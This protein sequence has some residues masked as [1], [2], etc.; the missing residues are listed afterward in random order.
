MAIYHLNTHT[1]GRAAGHSAVAAAAYRSASKLVDER[2]GEVFDFTRKGGVLSAEIVTPAGVP[3]PERAALWNAAEAAEKR[4]DARVARE[5]RAALPHELNEADRRELATRMGQAIA[6]RYGVA[7]DVCIHA[8]D[9]E[10][11]DRNFHVHM[12]ATTR[13][14]GADGALGAKAV[15]E[16]ANK[17]RQKAGIPGTSQGDIT[18]IRREWAELTNEALERAGISARIDHRSYADQGVEL[19]PTR[20]I[21]SDAVAMER[22]GLDADRIDIHKADRQEQARQIAERPEIILDKITATQAV[23][24]RRDIAAELNR[25]IDDAGQF[26]GLLTKLENSPLL[27]E[28]EPANGRDPAKFSTREMIDT[29]RGMVECAER[30]ARAGRHGVS[31]PITNAAI[32]GAGTLSAEQQNA[33]RHVLKPGSLAVVIGDAGTGKSFSM[34]VAREAWQAQ[35]FNVRG[36]ALAGKAADELQAGSGIE[37]RTLASLEFAWK[38]GKDKLTSRDVLVIDEAGMIGSRQLGRVLKAAEQAGAKVVLLGDD[39]QLAAIEAGAA[40]RAV[41]QHVGAAE[42]TEVRRQKHAWMREAGQQL[43]RGSVADGLAAYA[44]RGHVQIHGSREAARDALAASYVADQGK[45]SQII[46]AHSNAD[47]Q[48]L[49]QAVRDARKER[50]ELA[51]SARFVTE[52]G[53]REFAAGDRI[54]FLK[55]DRDLGVKNGTLGTVERAEDGR[56]AVRLDSG[57]AR[58]VQASQYAA[59]DHGYAVTIHKAQGVT[60][61]RAYLLATPGMDRSLAYVGMTR[62]R[63]AATLFAGADDFTDRR[64]GRLVDHG[65]APYEHDPKNGLSYFA[66]LENDKGERHTI[67]GVDLERAIADSGAQIGDRIGLAHGGAQ[68]VRLP[69]GRMVERNTWHVQTAEELA[70]GKLAQVMGRQRV[71]EST[72]DYLPDFAEQRGF[73]GESVLRRWVERGRAKVA[74]LAGRMRDAL[75]RGLE[76]HGRPDLMPATDIAGTPAVQRPQQIEQPAA[77]QRPQAERPAPDPLAGFRAGVERAEAAG[78]GLVLDVAKAQLAV[79]QEFQAAGKDPRHHAAAIMQEG[80]QRAFA[81][82]AQPSQAKAEPERPAAVQVSEQDRKRAEM[83]AKREADQFKALAV[84]RQAGFAGYTDRNPSAWREL[85]AELRERIERFNALPKERQAVELDKMQRELADRYARDPKEIERSR[86]RQREQERGN[87]GL[88]R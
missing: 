36:A 23:F 62:H 29:E 56:L 13:T 19:T 8:P 15:I 1:I 45:G 71:K 87:G 42:I 12:L 38:N 10:G 44:E 72:L 48:A 6:D 18:D 76:R 66:T 5:W 63:E 24:T 40:F 74:A 86:Q 47:V 26:Q 64:A 67:W 7:V 46:L 32:D 30:L 57:E 22:R 59:V 37:S 69:D 75:R 61:D 41:V 65:A 55:N 60:V 84:K 88:S 21:G 39:K 73:D 31:G 9:R 78:G 52:R 33:V 3:V 34:K 2:T 83:Y 81:G 50:G 35:G 54:V 11:D 28:M 25:Y 27:V 20:H 68:T 43:A 4:K 51:G 85:P 17:D 49:N 80:Q 79:A 14:I 70:A 58:Q 77:P 82:L 16:L 53:G